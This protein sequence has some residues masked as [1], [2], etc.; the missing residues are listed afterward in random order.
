MM[1]YNNLTREHF[2]NP[3]A[4]GELSGRAIR[5]G[6]AGAA[7]LGTWV[8]FDVRIAGIGAPGRIKAARFRAFGCPHVIAVA[9][10]L[11]QTASGRAATPELP[12]SVQALRERFDVPIEKLGR[13]LVVE[14]AWI[15]ALTPP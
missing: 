10:W 9:N 11:A 15:A 8:Q 5:R 7:A 13:L 14:D 2:E 3:A 6:A 1:H 4:A 12:D